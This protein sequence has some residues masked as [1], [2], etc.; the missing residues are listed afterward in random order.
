MLRQPH[1]R[2]G[3]SDLT[4]TM[5]VSLS[6][7]QCT[8]RDPCFDEI[9]AQQLERSVNASRATSAGTATT[10]NPARMG[11]AAESPPVLVSSLIAS[12]FMRSI[13]AVRSLRSV[14]GGYRFRGLYC[15]KGNRTP[16]PATHIVGVNVNSR[17]FVRRETYGDHNHL[18]CAVKLSPPSRQFGGCDSTEDN[19]RRGTH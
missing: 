19:R 7:L 12:T 17:F 16:K 11:I 10:F 3:C 15:L 4:D 5:R 9:L 6:S 2:A 1:S 18:L 13:P 8:Q 14:C